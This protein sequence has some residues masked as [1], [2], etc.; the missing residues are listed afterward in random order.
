MYSGVATLFECFGGRGVCEKLGELMG[1]NE[2]MIMRTK[3]EI[4]HIMLSY[5]MAWASHVAN[6][7]A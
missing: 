7:Y 2:E 5:H 1:K 6:G 3:L 4:L